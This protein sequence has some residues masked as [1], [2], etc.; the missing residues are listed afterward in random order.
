MSTF[1]VAVA[2]LQRERAFRRTGS[3]RE[4]QFRRPELPRYAGEF[5]FHRQP[6][7]AVSRALVVDPT[8]C[9]TDHGIFCRIGLESFPDLSVYLHDESDAQTR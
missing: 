4:P 2:V 5:M 3:A 8:N 9:P 7:I 1:G 6:V